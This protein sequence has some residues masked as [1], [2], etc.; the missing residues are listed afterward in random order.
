[1]ATPKHAGYAR[2][3]YNALNRLRKLGLPVDLFDADFVEKERQN[4]EAHASLLE[5]LRALEQSPEWEGIEFPWK[6]AREEFEQQVAEGQEV[7][8]IATQPHE[9]V[10]KNAWVCNF[11]D[12]RNRWNAQKER[13]KRKAERELARN[14]D[15]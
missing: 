11:M 2:N 6:A 3:L 14:K 12:W 10:W 1:M 8:F 7:P 4:R 15:K 5:R 9:P 13:D